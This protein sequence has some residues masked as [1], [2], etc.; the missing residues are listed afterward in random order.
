MADNKTK[1]TDADVTAFIAAIDNERRRCDA[2]TLIDLMNRVTGFK[3]RLW[4]DSIVGYGHYRYKY[5]SGH[6]GESFLTGFSPR[7]SAMTIY[8]MPGFKQ[9]EKELAKLGKHKHSVSCLYV[10]RLENIDLTVLQE[11]VADSVERM[12]EMYPEWSH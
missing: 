6:G 5:K 9:Y 8:V 12:K 2:Q 4:G 10:T 7:K 11:I 1:P 3:P